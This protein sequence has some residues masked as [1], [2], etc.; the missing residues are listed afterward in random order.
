[1]SSSTLRRFVEGAAIVCFLGVIGLPLIGRMVALEDALAFTENRRPAPFPSLELRGWSLVSFPRRFERYWNDSFA[2]R[3]VL[4]R[5]H[6]LLKLALGVSPSAKA[7]VGRDGYLF[8]AAE[9]SV[10]YYRGVSPFT[11]AAV[12]R[13]LAELEIRRAWLSE[14][15]IRYL[16]VI[17]PNKEM[18]YPEHMPE[19]LGPVRKTTRLDQLLEHVRSSSTL[20]VLDLREPLRAAKSRA[21]VYHRTDTHWNDVGAF[22]A[23]EHIVQRLH[24]WFPEM[25]A[26]PVAVSSRTRFKAAGDLARLIALEDR[27]TEEWIELVPI[28]TRRAEDVTSRRAL[29]GRSDE[30]AAMECPACG[31]PRAI[32][33]HDSFNTNLA[34]FL[35]EHFSRIVYAAGTFFDRTL[36]EDEHP[37][38]VIQQFVE[39]VLMCADLRT[40]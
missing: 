29:R 2:F 5:W 34:P 27:F 36:I 17:V 16:V 19:A 1:M 8:Y 3:R 23:Y 13:W 28:A 15:G 6:S 21:H 38:V 4:I 12:A 10:D 11:P 40:C 39:R 30:L 25:P 7:V 26:T 14:R 9:Q 37:D 35:A 24:R 20:E 18:I 33:F 32:M 31:G 22:V